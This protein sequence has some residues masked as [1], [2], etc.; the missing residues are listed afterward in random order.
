M[1]VSKDHLKLE[2][3]QQEGHFR[4]KITQLGRR[5]SVIP[6]STVPLQVG[7]VRYI[8]IGEVSKYLVSLPIISFLSGD[9]FYLI[10]NHF[11]FRIQTPPE[12]SLPSPPPP[13]P[14]GKRPI[15]PRSLRF[16]RERRVEEEA[17]A[18]YEIEKKRK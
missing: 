13:A 1:R 15:N 18:K 16:L 8:N 17:S 9:T 6:P 5:G 11:P 3:E 10:K 12:P 14:K 7:E 2:V 4:I